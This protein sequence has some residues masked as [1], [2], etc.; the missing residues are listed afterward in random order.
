MA[1]TAKRLEVIKGR[2]T[3][4]QCPREAELLEAALTATP[5]RKLVAGSEVNR[6]WPGCVTSIERL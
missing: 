6:S 4:L 2:E 5:K 3:A 1:K